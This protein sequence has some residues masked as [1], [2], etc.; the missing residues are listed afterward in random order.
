MPCHRLIFAT[1]ALT[2]ATLAPAGLANA[3]DLEVRAKPIFDFRF[4]S[5]IDNRVTLSYIPQGTGRGHW[6][7]NSNGT[8]NGK[9]E[10]QLYSFTHF[11]SWT[12]GTNI[13]AVSMYKSGVPVANPSSW[14]LIENQAMLL[15]D[16]R[17]VQT[18]L[19]NG[20][21][22]AAVASCA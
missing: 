20:D 15:L 8:I 13:F 9:T 7:R 19:W 17:F 5:L 18:D 10:K 1:A 22:S 3:D 16:V 12:C 2:L 6:S 4:F 11:D 21:R 14:R